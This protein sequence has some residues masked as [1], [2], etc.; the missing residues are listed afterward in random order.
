MKP[1]AYKY[2]I[3]LYYSVVTI[4]TANLYKNNIQ[5][6]MYVHTTISFRVD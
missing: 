2:A 3:D 4:V 6:L 5:E 1:H